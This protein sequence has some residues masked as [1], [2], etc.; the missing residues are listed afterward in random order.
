[1]KPSYM[2]RLPM[3]V[4]NNFTSLEQR[5]MDDIVRR[6]VKTGDITSTADYQILRLKE[7]GWSSEDIE[8]SIKKAL[9]ASYPDMYELYDIAIEKEYTRC[10]ELYEQINADY[11]PYEDNKQLQQI[12]KAIESQANSDLTNITQSLGFCLDYGTGKPVFTPLS[13]VFDK[14]LD[15]ACMDIVTGTFDYN[16]VLRRTV[17]ELTNSGLRTID[18]ASGRTNRVNVAARRAVMT[19][20]SNITNQIS[21]YNADKLGTDYYEVAWHGGARPSHAEWQGKVYTKQQLTTVCGLGTATGLCGINCY[22]EYYPFIKGISQRQWT[23]EWLE[24]ENA[25]ESKPRTYKGKEYTTYEATQQQRKLETAMRAQREKVRLL[26][27]G[28]ADPDTILDARCKYR[29]QLYEYT[30]FSNKMGLVQQ[31]ERIYLDMK[32]R[33]A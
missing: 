6:I 32:G 18:Y 21:H 33:V 2:E 11:V 15:Q 13:E 8:K 17:T 3:Q 31:R 29:G 16:S 14:Y 5:V 19:G 1:M 4:V 9:G 25:K 22:H 30:V 10:K 7:M 26:Q 23:D 12:I 27:S 24:K 20:L 28:K